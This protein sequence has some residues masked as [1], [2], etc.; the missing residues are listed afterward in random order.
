MKLSRL[1][2]HSLIA[3]LGALPGTLILFWIRL[4]HGHELF[5]DSYALLTAW[6]IQGV[7]IFAFMGE[8]SPKETRPLEGN[9]EGR[10][11]ESGSSKPPRCES[12]SAGTQCVA[13]AGHSGMCWNG[14]WLWNGSSVQVQSEEGDGD[15]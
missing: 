15:E 7:M 3:S 6:V 2:R 5:I 1:A 9:T 4:E 10:I 13:P 14:T 11:R 12:E 8:G